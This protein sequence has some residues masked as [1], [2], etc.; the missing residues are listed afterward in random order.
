[1]QRSEFGNGTIVAEGTLNFN[2]K[3]FTLAV[4][5]GYGSFGDSIGEVD[6]ARSTGQ[7]QELTFELHGT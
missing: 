1:M 2:A 5:G 6:A 4:T 3:T 7:S